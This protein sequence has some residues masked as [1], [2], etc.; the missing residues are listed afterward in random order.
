MVFSL[1]KTPVVFKLTENSGTI[2]KS[3]YNSTPNSK[4][5]VNL[6]QVEFIRFGYTA[7]KVPLRHT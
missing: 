4:N 1:L 7:L 3:G 2:H 5:L 6:A